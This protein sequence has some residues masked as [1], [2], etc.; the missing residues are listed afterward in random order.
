MLQGKLWL[1][2]HRV[3]RNA[4]TQ[5]TSLIHPMI[6]MF[7]VFDSLWYHCLLWVPA[8]NLIKKKKKRHQVQNLHS[9]DKTFKVFIS[10]MPWPQLVNTI[11]WK[12]SL[13]WRE[14]WSAVHPRGS[15]LLVTVG[16]SWAEASAAGVTAGLAA[17]AVGSREAPPAGIRL[18]LLAVETHT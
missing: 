16:W 15:G 1:P 12:D 14:L 13:I 2:I 10:I 3:T 8:C 17:G 18:E 9:V 11:C 5:L 4:V 7:L 6:R